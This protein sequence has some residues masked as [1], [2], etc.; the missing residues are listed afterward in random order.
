MLQEMLRHNRL[1]SLPGSS[2]KDEGKIQ[3]EPQRYTA[4]SV[5]L[6]F[7]RAVIPDAFHCWLL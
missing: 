6:V 7:D 3:L 2:K 1:H 4:V 5:V